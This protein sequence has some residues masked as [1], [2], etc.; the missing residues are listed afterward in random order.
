[1]DIGAI[2][3]MINMIE[4][5]FKQLGCAVSLKKVEDMAVLVHKTM[6]I[7]PRTFHTPAHVFNLSNPVN[8]IQTLAA[9][10]H[11]VVY[12]QVDKGFSPEIRTMLLQYI[13]EEQ[14]EIFIADSIDAADTNINLA[15]DLYDFKPGQKLSPFGGLNEF[16]STLVMIVELEALFSVTD[17]LKVIVYI[18]STIPFREQGHCDLLFKRIQSASLKYSVSFTDTEIEDIIKEAV[19]F[20]NMDVVSFA[21]RD[22]ATFLDNTWKLLPE[23]NQALHMIEVY[24]IK[25]Y[26]VSLQKMEGFFIS[27]DPDTVF[28]S[29]KGVPSEK[30]FLQMATLTR[31]NIETAREYLGVKLVTIS[32]L[33]ALADLTGGDAPLSLFM[34]D[35]RKEGE[36]MRRLEDF[37]PVLNPANPGDQFSTIFRLLDAGRAHEISFDMKNS[38]LSLF[39]YKR[40][41]YSAIKDLLSHAREM[42]NSR[43]EAADFLA[44]IDAEVVST[45]AKAA[46][47][48]VTTREEE[49]LKF[50]V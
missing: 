24:S 21:E 5:A 11:D 19:L 7:E 46:A 45:I 36:K 10:F 38:P 41:G 33:E 23:T 2:Q 37:L 26:R 25:D 27:L 49:L 28:H 20:S 30:E 31:R 14:E 40:I 12:Y 17:L 4:D 42:F 35:I 29:F 6:S 32:I 13:R 1:M 48:M 44:K 16:L 39:L 15:L 9:F 3:R 34:G 18:E 43:L 50:T 8:P 22:T 47:Y